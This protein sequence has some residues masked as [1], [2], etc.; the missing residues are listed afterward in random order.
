MERVCCHVHGKEF[1][2]QCL[3][4]IREQGIVSVAQWY[5]GLH[6]TV[7]LMAE[8]NDW[9]LQLLEDFGFGWFKKYEPMGEA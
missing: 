6:Y 9:Y 5:F 2:N 3:N 1:A 4:R 8:G 7:D